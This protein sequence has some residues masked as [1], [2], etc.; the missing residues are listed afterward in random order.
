MLV[1][2][3]FAPRDAANLVGVLGVSIAV[4]RLAIGFV[5]DR[6]WAPGVAACVLSLPAIGA[7]LMAG[8]VV[9]PTTAILAIALLGFAQGAEYDFLA[10]L[11]ARYFGMRHYGALY[12]LLVIPVAMATAIGAAGMG[13]M[14]D[15][16]GSFNAGL[17]WIG[18]AF[19]VG[20]TLLLSLGRY[21]P[22]PPAPAAR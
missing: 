6:V 9:T 11:A 19:V 2:K 7:W 14:R 18:V 20:G 4:G 12:G 13:Y 1:S 17:P 5:I 22:V 10:F 15:L 3:D 21:P 8:P 16:T